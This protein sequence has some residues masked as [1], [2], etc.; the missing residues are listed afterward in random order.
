MDN[1]DSLTQA[2]NGF[3]ASAMEYGSRRV[4]PSVRAI[5]ESLPKI[6]NNV[7]W[8]GSLGLL[9]FLTKAGRHARVPTMI[10]RDR[11]ALPILSV[12]STSANLSLLV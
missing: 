9:E 6:A 12:T 11:Y 1:V 4:P 7:E 2:V 10:S 5:P 8:L 3:F